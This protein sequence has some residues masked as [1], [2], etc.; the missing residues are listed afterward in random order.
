MGGIS[1]VHSSSC[2]SINR[3]CRLA[4]SDSA[5][6]GSLSK[7]RSP[8]NPTK[9]T[10]SS[11]SI[12]TQSIEYFSGS[13]H[14]K[15]SL[16]KKQESILNWHTWSFT[17]CRNNWLQQNKNW[18]KKILLFQP[19]ICPA[20]IY[21][22]KQCLHFFTILLTATSERWHVYDENLHKFGIDAHS[23]CNPNKLQKCVETSWCH[24][25]NTSC[26][27]WLLRSSLQLFCHDGKQQYANTCLKLWW[28]NLIKSQEAELWKL[29]QSSP[30]NWI[31]DLGHSHHPQVHKHMIPRNAGFF[32]LNHLTL[33]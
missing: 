25:T 4:D 21:A 2:L 20:E 16:S 13:D 15:T 19:F 33:E 29:H 28:S 14:N 11:Q 6:S 23:H 10:S 7:L 18:Q 31:Q 9:S 32:Q 24:L 26:K 3:R 27:S 22:Q 12:M 30:Q 17:Q 1:K 8:R 5:G